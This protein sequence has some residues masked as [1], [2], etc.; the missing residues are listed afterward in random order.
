MDHQHLARIGRTAAGALLAIGFLAA[1]SA[2]ALPLHPCLEAGASCSLREIATAAGVRIGSAAQPANLS[3][4]LYAETLA[5]EFNSITAENQMKWP[6][7]HPSEANYDFAPA[8]ALVAFAQA[9]DMTMRGH[10]L[11][12][13][14]PLRIPAWVSAAPDAETLR[15]WLENHIETVV[16]RYAGT[17]DSWDVINEPLQ[18]FSSDLY[19]NVF[20]DLLGEDYIAEAFHIAHAADPTAE[21]FL[22]EVLVEEP[23]ARFDAFYDLVAGL[24]ADGVPIHGVGLQ[25]H[26][27]AGII[28]PG[29]IGLREVIEAFADL[30]L[31]VEITEFDVTMSANG[32]AALEIQA[33]IYAEL[34]SACL[35]LA[36]CRGI[37]FWGFTDAHTWIEGTFGPGRVPLPFDE[38][39]LPKPAYDATRQALL[40]RLAAVPEPSGL[41]L[42]ATIAFAVA[43]G[44]RRRR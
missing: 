12:W 40:G 27:V 15:A 32:P 18:N 17:V 38:E 43:A 2:D 20:L 25:G 42:A 23:N 7:I 36:A 37:T 26:I 35:D 33:G 14:N 24:V 9:N 44:A 4:P 39:Y 19:D 34:L 41:A 1:G 31:V 28:Q 5:R 11:L 13:A 22:N 10:T 16:T 21:L 29:G 30:G 3:E 8:D 6:A